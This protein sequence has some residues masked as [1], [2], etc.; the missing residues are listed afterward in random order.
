MQTT[1]EE[2][3]Q[4]ESAMEKLDQDISRVEYEELSSKFYASEDEKNLHLGN[5]DMID[6]ERENLQERAA[7]TEE[8]LHVLACARQQQSVAEEKEELDLLREKIKA[9]RQQG[10]DLEPERKA[11]GFALRNLFEKYLFENKEQ[12]NIQSEYIQKTGTQAEEESRRVEDLEEKIRDCYGKKGKLESQIEVYSRQEEQFNTR[13]KEELVRNIVGA[14]EAGTLEIR[15]QIYEQE[16]TRIVRERTESQKKL[17][18]EKEM[19][20]SQERSVEDK[21]EALVHKKAEIQ[22]QTEVYQLYEKELE[23]RRNILKYLDMEAGYLLDRDRILNVSERKLKELEELRRSLEKEEDILEKEYQNLTS[24]KVL[25]LPEDLKKELDNLGIHI[26]YGME[27]LQKNGYSQKKNQELVRRNPFLPYALILS[28]QEMEKLAKS[29]RNICTSFPV[30]I[31]EREKIEEIQEILDKLK[32]EKQNLEKDILE[33]AQNLDRLKKEH[34]ELQ[35]F[36]VKTGLEIQNQK[37]RIA[38]FGQLEKDYA[39]YESNRAALEKC[40]KEEQ[41]FQEKQKLAKERQAK[42]LE[43]QKTAQNTLNILEREAEKLNEKYTRYATYEKAGQYTLPEEISVEQMEA[44]YVAITS[45]LS[46]ELK[47]LEERETKASGRFQREQNELEHLQKKYR[48]KPVQ[49]ADVIYDR[50]EES[51]QE[52]ILEDFQRKIQT[53]DMQWN[54]ADKKAAVAQSKSNDLQ[55]RIHSDVEKKN[56]CPGTRSRDRTLKHEGT[57]F[58]TRRKKRKD[59]LIFWPKKFEVMKKT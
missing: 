29:G 40:K 8:K 10:A 53:K 41:R 42:L 9:A 24:G 36:I 50:K 1:E 35:D 30:P 33:T 23:T 19:I 46:Q 55:K 56:H 16:L 47:D 44:R 6:M 57:S 37:Q 58:F 12:Q 54:D 7:E 48:L 4:S 27:W 17:E 21:K 15:H 31:V 32:E 20:R 11:L 34:E 26:V 25:E 51:H 38:D 28:G 5:R 52:V 3:R 2:Y 13:Y 49:W 59:M 14:Y 18:S 43:E 39:I 45:V 22:R